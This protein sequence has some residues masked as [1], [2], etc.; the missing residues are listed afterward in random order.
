MKLH[1][2]LGLL[3]TTILATPATAEETYDLGTLVI[4]GGLTPV[5]AR[6]YGRAATVLTEE[7]IEESG[8]QYVADVLRSLPGVAVSRTGGFGGRTQVRLRGHESNHTLVLIDG[9]EVAAPDQ[10]EYDFAGL[11]TADIARI[12]I[13]RGPQSALYG[14]NAIGGVISITTKRPTEPGISGEVGFEVGS[15]GTYEGRIAVRQQSDRGQLSFSAARRE[16]DGFDISG[17]PG[18]EDDGDLNRTY[19]LTG[20]FFVTDALTVGGTLRHVD[21]VSDTDGFVF[22]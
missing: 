13:I 9:V 18:G 20:R 21:R 5:E 15:D 17:T 16:T 4:S 7:E 3:A 1:A 8:E 11:L 6:E 14:S 19:N 12:E 2:R 22:G 10:G